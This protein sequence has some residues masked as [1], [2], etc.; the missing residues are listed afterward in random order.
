MRSGSRLL[1]RAHGGAFG[2]A[3]LLAALSAPAE[4][5]ASEARPFHLALRTGF[6]LPLGSYADVRQIGPLRDEDVISLSDD[7][8]GAIPLWL[9]LGYRVHPNVMLGA[10][11][12]YGLVLPK[13]AEVDNPLA[14][15][16]PEGLDCFG[17]GI[18]AGLQAQYAFS[19]GAPIEPWLGVALGVEWITSHVQGQA[20]G[21]DLDI[22]TSHFGPDPLQL[23]GGVDFRL[24]P[25]FALG[26]FAA[27][28]VMQYTSCTA[29]LDGESIECRLPDKAWHGWLVLGLRGS[30]GL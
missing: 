6:G 8:H 7:V 14:G 12:M 21:F 20:F 25:A 24:G 29:E 19:P 26:P 18:R 11:V 28:S 2:L 22:A 30:L 27:L 3:A 4:P 9:D 16:C 13:S 10:Y 1:R 23:Q 17:A 5:A 15:G